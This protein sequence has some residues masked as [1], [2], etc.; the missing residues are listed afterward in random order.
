MH[1]PMMYR[2]DDPTED[3]P[4]YTVANRANYPFDHRASKWHG[5][6]CTFG[7]MVDEIGQR[8][9]TE[10]FNPVDDNLTAHPQHRCRPNG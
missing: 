9:E 3:H 4:K 10:M 7:H 1:H 6:G 5:M 2:D 8:F